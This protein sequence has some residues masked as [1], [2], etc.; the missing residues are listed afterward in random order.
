[1]NI[2]P[3]FLPTRLHEAFFRY[4]MSVL[5]PGLH[6]V[7]ETGSQR[8]F[9]GATSLEYLREGWAHYLAANDAVARTVFRLYRD[10]DVA[11]VNDFQ[12]S[13]MPRALV[14]ACVEAYGRR[15]PQLF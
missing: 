12:L 2:V 4:C 8:I 3:I 7:L 15:P 5:R 6:N 11:W 14:R 1:M 9:P 10:G 13:M